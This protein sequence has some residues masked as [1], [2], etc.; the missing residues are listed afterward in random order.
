[1]C[2]S[3][4]QAPPRGSGATTPLSVTGGP[5]ARSILLM[6]LAAKKPI[7][8]PSGDQNGN[9]APSVPGSSFAAGESSARTQRTLPA[10]PLVANVT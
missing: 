9:R 2:P 8:F 6:R 3:D 4:V 1:M 7:D 10:F 5:P